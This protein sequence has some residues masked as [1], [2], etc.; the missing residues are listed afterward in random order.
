MSVTIQD[1]LTQAASVV[2]LQDCMEGMAQYPDKWFDLAVVDPP[3]FK[4]VAKKSF[5]G[6]GLSG[7]GNKRGN[8]KD[9]A[10]WDS[11]IPESDY[12][13]QLVRISNHQIIW[14]INYFHFNNVPHGR[15]IWDKVND[16]STFSKAEIASCSIIESVQIFRYRWCG[17]Q[18]GPTCQVVDERFHPTQK[19]IALYD[20]IYKNY[21]PKGGKV[22]DTHLGSGSNRIAAYKAG[23]IDFVGYEID[24]DYYA[25][26]EKRFIQHIAQTKLF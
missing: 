26:Q 9:I 18:Q 23:N 12:Y 11:N 24:A 20:W 6:N 7:S 2:H 10:A 25:A 16:A 3:F 21:L 14:G 4:G 1:I 15:L 8:Y 19:P 5:Y 13:D 22:I 17:F